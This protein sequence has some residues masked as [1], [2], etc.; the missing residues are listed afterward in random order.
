MGINIIGRYGKNVGIEYRK[1]DRLDT[2]TF[3]DVLCKSGLAE[4]RP[5]GDRD[6]IARMLQNAT[7]IIVAV[8]TSTQGVVG[9]ARSITDYAYCCYLSDLAVDK[10]YQ[11]QWIGKRLIDET[12]IA[13]GPESICLLLSAPDALPFYKHIGMPQADNAFFYKRER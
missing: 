12:R 4:G 13:A 2:D 8:D 5:V 3:I 6:R 7:L 10:A 1:V 9:V 11:G